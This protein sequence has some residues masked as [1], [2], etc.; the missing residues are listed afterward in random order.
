MPVSNSKNNDQA[1]MQEITIAPKI[2]V[3][4]DKATL[5]SLAGTWAQL[6]KNSKSGLTAPP[7]STG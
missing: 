6:G 7:P 3:A 4:E 1:G 2:E 5:P